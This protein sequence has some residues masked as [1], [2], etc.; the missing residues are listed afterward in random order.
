MSE[1]ARQP[2]YSML[3]EWSDED[4]VYI[5]SFPEWGNLAH[6][7]GSNYAE[8]V[9][10]GQEKRRVRRVYAITDSIQAGGAEI[11]TRMASSRARWTHSTS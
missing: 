8:T 5:V 4:H 1:Q 2:H 9:T 3:I 11:D 10:H 6:K 7:H